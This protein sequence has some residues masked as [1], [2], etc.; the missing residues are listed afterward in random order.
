MNNYPHLH[1]FRTVSVRSSAISPSDSRERHFLN[2]ILP[3]ESRFQKYTIEI[4]GNVSFK[5]GQSQLVLAEGIWANQKWQNILY[6][7]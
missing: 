2:S 4:D 7:S 5:F 3:K 6:E 1:F